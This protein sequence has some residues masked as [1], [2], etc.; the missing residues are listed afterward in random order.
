MSGLFTKSSCLRNHSPHLD[1]YI[2]TA[3]HFATYICTDFSKLSMQQS[4]RAHCR[5]SIFDHISK[6]PA[7]TAGPLVSARI[8]ISDLFLP[9]RSELFWLYVCRRRA[10]EW[11]LLW[12]HH[13]GNLWRI[14]W[15]AGHIFPSMPWLQKGRTARR[16]SRRLCS[17]NRL[18]KRRYCAAR[19]FNRIW[20]GMEKTVSAMQSSC[21]KS[22][23]RLAFRSI[24]SPIL[25]FY[26]Q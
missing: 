8:S 17:G 13:F 20:P 18:N 16:L 15:Q 22:W 3:I 14:S 9:C 25:P 7:K 11:R 12:K 23:N 1:I 21:I 2:I 4:L 10:A 26:A 24:F 19:R 6:I 5:Q